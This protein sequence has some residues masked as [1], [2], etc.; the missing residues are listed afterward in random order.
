M[1]QQIFADQIE[2]IQHTS[3]Y[4]TWQAAKQFAYQEG[5]S[6]YEYLIR[7]GMRHDTGAKEFWRYLRHLDKNYSSAIIEAL[8]PNLTKLIMQNLFE[9]NDIYVDIALCLNEKS[10]LWLLEKIKERSQSNP[11]IEYALRVR[12]RIQDMKAQTL[13]SDPL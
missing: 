5:I 2:N 1:D 10:P 7:Y 9:L 12:K 13:Y 4:T 3:D 6:L 8:N 11:N